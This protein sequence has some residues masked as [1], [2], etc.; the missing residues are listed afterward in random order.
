VLTR[1]V[2]A[3]LGLNMLGAIVLVHLKNG[4]FNPGGIEFPLALL[5]ICWALVLTGAGPWSV[6]GILARRRINS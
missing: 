1:P 2:A 5:G 3:L 6:D 4:F